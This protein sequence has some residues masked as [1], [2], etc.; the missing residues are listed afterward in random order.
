MYE[1]LTP[2]P[3]VLTSHA[4][5]FAGVIKTAEMQRFSWIIQRAPQC[6][7]KW[8]YK[9]QRETSRTEQAM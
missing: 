6:H 3:H 2:G 9:G 7:H 8:A 1:V 5:G 4:E